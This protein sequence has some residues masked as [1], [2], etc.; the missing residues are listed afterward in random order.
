V[1]GDGFAVIAA[2]AAVAAL[3]ILYLLCGFLAGARRE[4]LARVP[5]VGVRAPTDGRG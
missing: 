5:S 4:P 3:V 2:L 1:N